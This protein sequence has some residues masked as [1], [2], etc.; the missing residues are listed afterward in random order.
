MKPKHIA[1]ILLLALASCIGIKKATDKVMKDPAAKEK[2]GREWEKEN[3]CVN[4]TVTSV[5]TAYQLLFT[6]GAP[7]TVYVGDTVKITKRD[8]VKQRVEVITTKT[9]EDTRRLRLAR[10]T[11]STLQNDLQLMASELD[12]AKMDRQL[13]KEQLDAMERKTQQ[14]GPTFKWFI[15]ALWDAVKW[16]LLVVLVGTV[17]WKFRKSIPYLNKLPI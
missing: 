2:V 1:M 16:W 10:D 15:S 7:D 6:E 17:I 4:D 12:T 5:D 13:M 14:V 8:T 3:P 11:I 9:V